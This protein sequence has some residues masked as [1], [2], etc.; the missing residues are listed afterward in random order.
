MVD[1]NNNIGGV[2]GNHR[3]SGDGDKSQPDIKLTRSQD[4]NPNANTYISNYADRGKVLASLQQ[5]GAKTAHP[6]SLANL[7]RAVL[8]SDIGTKFLPLGATE[9]ERDLLNHA[10][11]NIPIS[12]N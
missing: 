12:N 1:F 11:H 6:N 7:S 9:S 2:G 8:A 5:L 4:V 3:I 10:Y